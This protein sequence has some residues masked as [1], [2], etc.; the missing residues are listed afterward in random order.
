MPGS[1]ASISAARPGPDSA[2]RW[3][4]ASLEVSATAI[5]DPALRGSA[6]EDSVQAIA[7]TVEMRDPYTAG[8][9][10]RV[11]QLSVAIAR[12]LGLSPDRIHGLHLAAIIHD[13]G[14][15]HVPAEILSKPGELS[16]LEFELIKTHAQIGHDIIKDVVFPW[17][18]ARMLLQHHE[19]PDGSG[20]PNGL[21]DADLLL[22]SKILTVADVVEAMGS[23]RPYRPTL[24]I[25][26]AVDH[27]K[28]KRGAWYDPAVVDACV[29]L[30][31]HG[32]FAFSRDS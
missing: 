6:Q 29:R 24:G 12:E 25:D 32:A 19:H 3:S 13:L 27:V 30:V 21:V 22:E 8:H 15:I 18:I 11:A 7:T 9:Q 4:I 17:P 28:D 14:K 1:S 23:H 31:R 16:R 10:Q 5:R 2:W 20:Y 26:A